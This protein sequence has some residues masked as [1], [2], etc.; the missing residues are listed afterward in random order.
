[1]LREGSPGR[2]TDSESVDGGVD[3]FFC[4]EDDAIESIDKVCDELENFLGDQS[5]QLI[6]MIGV[7]SVRPALDDDEAKDSCAPIETLKGRIR[8]LEAENAALRSTRLAAPLD[9]FPLNIFGRG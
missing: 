8:Q 9:H 1:M 5:A 3:H 2:L 6:E 4:F 7:S